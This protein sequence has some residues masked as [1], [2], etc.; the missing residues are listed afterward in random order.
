MAEHND[1]GRWGEQ[2]AA[3]YLQH[4]GYQIIE[5]DWKSGHRDLDI[6]ALDGDTVVFVEVKTRSNRMFTDPVDAVGYQK[7]RNLQI[8]A[9]HYVKYRQI[10]GD[11]RF[12]IVS[13]V[14]SVGEEPEIEH[15]VDA[16]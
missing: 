5:R 14:G 2:M 7:I 6:I 9:N 8:A 10:D 12:D 3:E 13:V 4:K 1:L 16:F 11:I 15:I